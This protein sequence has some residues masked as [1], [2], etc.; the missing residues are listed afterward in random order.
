MKHLVQFL[1]ACCFDCRHEA[2]S[3]VFTIDGRTYQVCCECG[4][5]FEYSWETMSVK[6]PAAPVAM[7]THAKVAG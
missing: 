5:E 4:R 3:R 1:V 6:R 7:V 2:R